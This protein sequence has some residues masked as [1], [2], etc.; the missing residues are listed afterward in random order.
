MTTRDITRLLA[1]ELA[2]LGEAALLHIPA[3]Q[4]V[5]AW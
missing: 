4:V 5:G 1:I 3:L 2:S